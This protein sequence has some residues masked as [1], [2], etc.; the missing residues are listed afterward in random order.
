MT[1][2][3]EEFNNVD[4]DVQTPSTQNNNTDN[5]PAVMDPLSDINESIMHTVDLSNEQEAFN[6]L[7]LDSNNNNFDTQDIETV[8]ST[9][10]FEEKKQAEK[11]ND[12]GKEVQYQQQQEQEKTYTDNDHLDPLTQSSIDA[13]LSTAMNTS[14]L[15]ETNNIN[16]SFNIP[17]TSSVSSSTTTAAPIN[18]TSNNNHNNTNNST[19]NIISNSTLRVTDPRKENDG[20][21]TFVTYGIQ[22]KNQTSRRRFQD[23]VWLYNVLYVHFPACIVPPLPDKHRLEYVKGDRFS[24]DFV[25][26][27]RASLER[28]LQR[29]ERHPILSR[30]QYFIMFLESPEFNDASARALRDGQDTVIDSIGDSLLNAFAKIKKPDQ[31][32][33]DMKERVD[34]LEEN[35]SLLEKT[36]TR[37]NKRTEDLSR[38]YNELATSIK[39]LGQLETTFQ[40]SLDVFADST[41]QYS[42]NM[43]KVASFDAD[44]LSEIHDYMS[45]HNAMKDVLKLRDQKQ[46]DFEELTDYLQ[47]TIRERE[48]IM[49]PSKIDNGNGYNLTGY[50]TD[51][52]NEV[53]G[54]DAEKIRRE[55]IL[56]LDDR[57]HELQDAIEQTNEVSNA[58]S[59]QV[60]KENEYFVQSNAIE[61]HKAL[62]V[63]A[64]AK[65]DFYQK[66]VNIWKNVVQSLEAEDHEEHEEHEDL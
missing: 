36:L 10:P 24:T 54:A 2:S 46:L 44:W 26:K 19:R 38:D 39:G 15:L 5:E 66:G 42:N 64:D 3:T 17:S 53:R 60:K 49:H 21:S 55:K 1:E 37:T 57:I 40:K 59:D 51:K 61:M 62:Q 43:N 27:R 47:A 13:A 7:S 56:R 31:Q 22:S 16:H 48:K 28:F 12:Q 32:F 58:F 35:F 25:E 9:H 4:W 50:L 18:S 33:V 52:I 23:F 6:N 41:V 63:Y 34:R 29:I 11:N 14:T 20:Q 65:V 45:Y 8:L 30:S